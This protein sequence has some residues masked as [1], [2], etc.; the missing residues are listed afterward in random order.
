MARPVLTAALVGG[1]SSSRPQATDE[2]GGP[3]RAATHLRFRRDVQGLRAVAVVAVVLEHVVGWPVGGFVGVDVF[4]V[5]SGYLITGLLL[6]EHELTGRISLGDFYRRRVRRLLPTALVVVV[7]TLAAC[8][9]LLPSVRAV[10]ATVDAAWSL[11]FLANWRFASVGTDYFTA[12]GPVSPLQHLWS[13]AV[14]EQFYAVWPLVM[15]A[16]LAL[17]SRRGAG[18]GRR[19]LT[20]VLLLVSAT[21]F[22]WAVVQSFDLPAAAYFSTLTRA[23]ELG[24]GAAAAVLLPVWRRLPARIG[25]VLS[26]G[27]TAAILASV[28]FVHDGLPFPGPWA[29]LPVLA[30]LAVLIGG[31]APGA[32]V[33]H[34]LRNPV[35]DSLGTVSYSLYLWHFPA[36]VVLTAVAPDAV[37]LA[38]PLS[39]G[40]AFVGHHL[41][42][43]PFTTSPLLAPREGATRRRVWASWAR[44]HAPRFVRASLGALV[45]TA[46]V[47]SA[48]ALGAARPL[49][50]PPELPVAA[51]D[52]AV[53]PTAGAGGGPLGPV[54]TAM[55]AAVR[56][57]L[58]ATT[59]PA[60]TPS[61]GD[62][63]PFGRRND[64]GRP[65]LSLPRV[66]CTFGDDSPDARTAV[67]VGDSTAAA[68][69]DALVALVEAPDSGWRLVSLAV[70][71]CPFTDVEVARADGSDACTAHREVVTRE[72]GE[73]RPELLLVTNSFVPF[74]HASTGRVVSPAEAAEGLRTRISG[75]ADSITDLVVVTPPPANVSL[76]QC[77]VASGSPVDCISRVDAD[78]AAALAQTTT[79]VA[80][81][82]GKTV[83]SSSFLCVG[84]QC[85]AFVSGVPVKVD[86][87]HYSEAFLAV[88]A[89]VLR[90]VFTAEDILMPVTEAAAA[91]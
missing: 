11:V 58:G 2:G 76:E 17:V 33:P 77:W 68:E 32:R 86:F 38:L 54:E 52:E 69:L 36:L 3:V 73:L 49:P 64:C 26:W 9:A 88:L 42:E 43:K 6:R 75:L 61:P 44:G 81:A 60:L 89:P 72:I 19:A 50:A 79:V 10:E 12:S 29:A 37:L 24:L 47:L 8:W 87:T 57:A 46:L 22:A 34:L 27:G 31:E 63:I 35:A 65:D 56:D 59:W 67:L 7:S 53:D 82:G 66:E 1:Q 78:H 45:L 14:E 90:E 48:V 83:D 25:T 84:G 28:I 71:G 51:A 41:V 80:E 4:F 13:L 15:I 16:V 74:D 62:G 21:S 91:G 40:L 5:I 30:T 39:L 55:R 23:W 20:T 85:P 18:R 70:Y